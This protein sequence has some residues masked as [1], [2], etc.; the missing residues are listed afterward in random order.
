MRKAWT[1]PESRSSSLNLGLQ[2]TLQGLV[3]V[4][5]ILNDLSLLLHLLGQGVSS[6]LYCSYQPLLPLSE[7]PAPET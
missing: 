2:Q 3:V 4:L 5:K 1:Y 7:P 6:G